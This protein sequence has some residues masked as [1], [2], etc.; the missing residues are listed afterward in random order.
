MNVHVDTPSSICLGSVLTSALGLGS[1]GAHTGGVATHGLTDVKERL[2][3]PQKC[4]WGLWE[5]NS[6]SWALGIRSR[7]EDGLWWA[8]SLADSDCVEGTI[9]RT[10]E[11]NLLK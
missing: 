3:R 7:S 11:W 6:G 2:A 9:R 5:R 1:E 4:V 10:P 8:G